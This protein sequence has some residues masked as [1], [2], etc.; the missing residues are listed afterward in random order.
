MRWQDYRYVAGA[1]I[2]SNERAARSDRFGRTSAQPCQHLHGMELRW[3]KLARSCQFTEQLRTF[4][5]HNKQQGGE[6]T[7][8]LEQLK[9][10]GNRNL[11]LSLSNCSK[12]RVW[13]PFFLLI[14]TPKDWEIRVPVAIH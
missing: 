13:F 6:L 3:L 8:H 14:H 9:R 11:W 5:S 12:L 4:T 2:I 7:D 1:L 10:H